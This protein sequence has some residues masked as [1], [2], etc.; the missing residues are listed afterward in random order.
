LS[1]SGECGVPFYLFLFTPKMRPYVALIYVFVFV[2]AATDVFSQQTGAGYECKVTVDLVNVSK[3][4]DRV[5]ITVTPPPIRARKIRYVLPAYLPGIGGKVDAGQFL[6][7]FYALDDQGQPVKAVKRDGGNVVVLKL[8]KGRTLRRLDYW[9]D[10]TW[11]KSES[12]NYHNGNYNYVPNATG[13]S[14]VSGEQYLMNTA[15][16]FGYF[17]GYSWVPYHLT[18]S[19]DAS[20]NAFTTLKGIE[21][22]ANRDEYVANSYTD[23]VEYPIF[24]G[25]PDT[26]GFLSDNIYIDI[27]VVSETGLTTARQIRRYIG[28]DVASMTRFLGNVSPRHYQMLFYLVSPKDFKAGSKGDFGGVAHRNSAVYYLL[29]STDEEQLINTVVRETSGDILKTLRL[30]D[31]SQM[32]VSGDFLEPQ[33]PRCWWLAEG[34]KS[35]FKWQAELRD[36]VAGEE[37]FTN[38][39]SAKI[40]LYSNVKNKSLTSTAEMAKAIQDPLVA[41][42]YKAKAMLTI[43]MLDINTVQLSGGNT[44]LREI[45]LSLNDSFGFSADSLEKYIL[46]N[47]SH[48]L[49]P[50]FTKYVHGTTEL[51]I[52]ESFEK[53]GWVYSPVALDSILT[54]GQVSMMYDENADAFFVRMADVGNRLTLQTGD[55]LV[56]INGIHVDAANMESAL[57]AIYSP[58]SDEA[59]EVIFIRGNQNVT[60]MSAPYYRTVVIDHL[61]RSDPASNTDALI[62]HDLIF[63]P[64]DY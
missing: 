7:E 3:D 23:I 62:L 22:Q 33:V 42:E 53:I 12:G 46:A 40:R 49:T 50:F 31:C 58:Q 28:A 24:Y 20:L 47:V 59:V 6:H 61:V 32:A 51:P 30:L 44:D 1:H 55:R 60:V 19:H 9:V 15:F 64:A 41:E 48:D 8:R 18:V 45:V 11:D 52:I 54:F 2:F 5:H 57:A 37:E 25:N 26:C 36:S 63:S 43:F 38:V 56:S 27:A 17:D 13:T 34:M 35:Y 21:K 29:E 10:D 4:K 16:M 14:F 39:I